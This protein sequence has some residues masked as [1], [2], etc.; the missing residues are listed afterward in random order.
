MFA[1]NTFVIPFNPGSDDNHFVVVFL[2]KACTQSNRESS[3]LIAYTCFNVFRLFE[4]FFECSYHQISS[5]LRRE[6]CDQNRQS[7]RQ[8]AYD[9]AMAASKVNDAPALIDVTS[10]IGMALMLVLHVRSSILSSSKKS[11]F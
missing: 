7:L 5:K 1:T 4:P 8:V 9:T 10:C 11:L 6:T 3:Q 2:N